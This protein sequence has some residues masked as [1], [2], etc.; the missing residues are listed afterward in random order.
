MESRKLSKAQGS[1][2]HSLR[3]HIWEKKEKN[4]LGSKNIQMF[5]SESK[6]AMHSRKRKYRHPYYITAIEIVL[7]QDYIP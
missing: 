1:F 3:E 6:C 2:H 7:S 5:H 4:R